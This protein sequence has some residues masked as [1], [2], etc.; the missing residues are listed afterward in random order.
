MYLLSGPVVAAMF[1]VALLVSGASTGVAVTGGLVAGVCAPAVVAGL[2]F[3]F[4]SKLRLKVIDK[5][6]LKT[7][8]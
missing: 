8:Q 6:P 3:V 7:G 2:L 4:K 1:I 5:L